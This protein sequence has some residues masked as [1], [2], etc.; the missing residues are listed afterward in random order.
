M[1]RSQKG[2][3][4]LEIIITLLVITL[5]LS[6]SYPTLSRATAS[7]SLRTT[8]R[9]IL[10][11][12]RYAREQAVTEQIGIRVSVDQENQLLHLTDDF[13]DG[14]RRYLLPEN[15]RI[16]SVYLGGTEPVDGVA[17]IRFLPNGSSDAV[18]ILIEST[19]TGAFMR[20]V[21]DPISSGASILYGSGEEVS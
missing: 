6:I 8:S 1:N 20:I 5:V 3:T 10:N 16:R 2:F 15:V 12:L 14:N 19:K 4:L 13:G 21:S 17:T 18:E 11:T 9:D 7:L